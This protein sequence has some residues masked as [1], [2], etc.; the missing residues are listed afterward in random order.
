MLKRKSARCKSESKKG[1]LFFLILLL[2][3][4]LFAYGGMMWGERN[5]RVLKTTWFD[6][7][8]PERAE[9]SAAVLYEKADKVYEEVTAQYGMTPKFRMPVVVVPG[10]EDFNAFWTAVPYNHIVLY[11][12]GVSGNSEL[13][14]FSE[15]LLSTFRHELTHAVTYNMKSDFFFAVDKVIGDFF[16]PGMLTVTS[17]M[18]EGATVTSE[19]AAGEGRLNDEFAK[20]YVKQAKIEGKFPSYHDVSG[21]S[22][23]TPGGAPYFFNGA[24]HQWLQETY[25]LEPYAQFWYSVV[26]GKNI[27]ITKCF[28]KAYG[29]SLKKAWKLF[30]EAY[31]VPAVEPDPVKAGLAANFTDLG[32]GLYISLSSGS[33]KVVWVDRYG[34]Q[35][36]Y[37]DKK[38]LASLPA[39]SHKLFSLNGID[40]ARVSQDGRFIA[41]SY[42]SVNSACETACVKIC[43]LKTRRMF[44]VKET[45][46][47]EACVI[48]AGNSGDYYLVAQRYA[49]QHYSIEIFK[50]LFENN[51]ICGVEP[52]REVVMPQEVN[53]FA[54]TA[55]TRAEAGDSD[56]APHTFA[57]LKKDRLQFS[58]CICDTE[59]QPVKEYFF[60]KGMAVRSL[61]FDEQTQSF[62]F[63]YAEKGTL[64]RAGK[65]DAVSGELCK[66][67]AD[68]SGGVFEPV[69]VDGRVLYVAQFFRQNRLLSLKGAT[70]LSTAPALTLETSA[71]T[72]P[73]QPLENSTITAPL[74]T[75]TTITQLPSTPYT[76]FPY[77]LHGMLIPIGS[78]TS[79]Y[80]GKNAG[81]SLEANSFPF[82]VTYVTGAPWT[83][84]GAELYQLTAGWNLLSNSFGTSLSVTNGTE[85][86][87]FSYN[88][89][90]KSEFDSK[91]WKQSG[92]SFVASTRLEFGNI[93]TITISNTAAAYVGRQ[94]VMLQELGMYDVYAFWDPSKIGSTAPADDTV[95]YEL[96]DVVSIQYSNIKRVGPG[97]FETA[98]FA[99][100]AGLGGRYDA[101]L[102]RYPRYEY[103]DIADF[104]ATLRIRI[105][106][107]LPFRSNYGYTYNLPLR[108]DAILFPSESIYGYATE[109]SYT[110]YSFFDAIAETTLFSMEIQKAVPFAEVLYLNDF[111]IDLGYACTG[112][113]KNVIQ[114][115]FKAANL[116]K[117]FSFLASGEASYFDA[118]FLRGGIEFTPNA[119]LFASSNYKMEVYSLFSLFMHSNR[120][121][122]LSQSWK[123]FVGTSLSF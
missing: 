36:F 45:G 50:V 69:Y 2:T 116:G 55:V 48:P 52:Y 89:E 103:V 56:L 100:G 25:G 85:T 97:R 7:I 119:G 30:K 57:Y 3:V 90:I 107:L 15:T 76:P 105:P 47:K 5:L 64:P 109:N 63:S 39:K 110:G 54:F 123:F 41:A 10:V 115:G 24:F 31:E 43:D 95:Y 121:R 14:V 4:K 87:L 9:E 82:G 84:G 92:G 75:P 35:V 61:S 77:L 8:Y 19:S 23:V 106:H 88:A 42:T 79:D 67:E 26:N 18:A 91:G 81:Y 96:L 104:S 68:I 73:V 38:D 70:A 51:K 46:L 80:F 59:G 74:T 13:A 65:L 44:S 58:L 49:A 118:V 16:A 29:I 20:H 111:Y 22:D 66:S 120:V 28:K 83:S 78:Y 71:I 99:I 62:Y 21:S 32:D 12:T 6:I 122:P 108:L 60:P 17:G 113:C 94:D 1:V 114:S 37:A 34:G 40:S 112:D 72:S 53:P 27:L 98:G 86:S 33:D 101:T 102:E 93:S 117:Y 11:D